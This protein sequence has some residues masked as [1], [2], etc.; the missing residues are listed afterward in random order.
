MNFVFLFFVLIV[1]FIIAEGVFRLYGYI[2]T[3]DLVFQGQG[4][5]AKVENPKLGHVLLPNLSIT[6]DNGLVYQT[7][8]DGLRDKEYN[9]LHPKDVYRIVIIGDSVTFGSGVNQSNIYPEILES[10]LN[11]DIANNYKI[12]VLNLGVSGYSTVSELELFKL[13]GL[14]YTPNLVVLAY[15]LNDASYQN[16]PEDINVPK[17][18][19]CKI[20]LINMP[21]NCKLK[22]VLS[23][24]VFLRA[25]RDALKNHEKQK[26]IYI[27]Y[28]NDLERWNYLTQQIDDLKFIANSNDFNVLVVVFPI[29]DDFNNYKWA[30]LHQKLDD[31]FAS[32]GFYVLDIY[33]NFKEYDANSLRVAPKD[34][35]HPNAE[36]HQIVA[37]AIYD[38]L[39]NGG[40]ITYPYN[41]TI[42]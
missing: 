42:A 28:H 41:Q 19:H 16:S 31:M 11:K 10:E 7:N 23:S 33:N 9:V 26:D 35:W 17:F 27:E 8:S 3:K 38:K 24:S 6:R 29:L 20:N 22:G 34:P 14:K 15:V 32:K 30:E 36:G 4:L 12:E 13:K 39:I 40:I 21:I 37:D 25:V 1:C 2:Q 18:T 5:H